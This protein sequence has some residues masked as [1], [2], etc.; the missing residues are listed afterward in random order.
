MIKNCSTCK[1]SPVDE[2]CKGCKGEKDGNTHWEP[3][4]FINKPC[5]SECVRHEKMTNKE[6]IEY[7]KNLRMYMKLSDKNQP[8]KFLEE[9]YI[10]LDMAI[11]AL[12]QQS[13]ED[14]YDVPSD[15]MTLEQAR[16]AVN[17]LRK[18]VAEYLE[19]EPSFDAK[20]KLIE[21]CKPP[22]DDWEHYADRLHD[23]AYQNG[24]EQAQKDLT[25]EDAISRQAVLDLC[26]RF[27]GCVPY[28]VLSN[29]DMLPSVQPKQR[30][31]KWE[32][33]FILNERYLPKFTQICICKRCGGK[34]YRYEGQDI[35]FCSSCG[36]KMKEGE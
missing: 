21:D 2:H 29:Y 4:P 8:C 14:W 17:D 36:A 25:C 1:H 31:G 18:K 9:N 11:K 16:Q 33:H 6:A 28:S 5:I 27:N 10:A 3:E 12:E 32:I 26:E 24:Y 13:C 15:E 23:I 19:K 22:T 7:N 34:L 35:S 30:T 20:Q